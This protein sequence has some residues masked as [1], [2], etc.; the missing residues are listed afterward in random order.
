VLR[1]KA[2][3]D[4][5][6]L[7]V[8]TDG[9]Y[10]SRI[11]DP[12][13]ARRMRRRKSKVSAAQIPGIEVRVIEYTV[14]LEGQYVE[15]DIVLLEHELVELNYLEAHLGATYREV[16]VYDPDK[17]IEPPLFYK[18]EM[19]WVPHDLFVEAVQVDGMLAALVRTLEESG[20][21]GRKL[22]LDQK[23]TLQR[24]VSSDALAAS[25]PAMLAEPYPLLPL[26]GKSGDIVTLKF[27]AELHNPR[28]I[29]E[30]IEKAS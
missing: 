27:E 23:I 28:V 20:L 6:V 7:R 9:S 14:E 29:Q 1:V 15:A 3:V 19:G 10:T 12:A 17:P 25:L 8:L 11:A 16:H 24:A 5:P 13:E 22:S 18:G 4:L 30:G 2:G 26:A 21:L